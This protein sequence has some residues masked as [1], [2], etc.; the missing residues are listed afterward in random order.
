MSC[1]TVN[2]YVLQEGETKGNV[3]VLIEQE[4]SDVESRL[5]NALK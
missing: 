2:I 3:E 5:K 1:K 4:G